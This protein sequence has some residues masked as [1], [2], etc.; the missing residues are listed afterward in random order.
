MEYYDS[1]QFNYM[2]FNNIE[3]FTDIENIG[4]T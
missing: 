4:N 2:E 3:Q 1:Y